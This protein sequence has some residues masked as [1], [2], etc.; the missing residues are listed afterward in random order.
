MAQFRQPDFAMHYTSL[1]LITES[2][3]IQI[4]DGIQSQAELANQLVGH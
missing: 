2:C 4:Q 1:L 3:M